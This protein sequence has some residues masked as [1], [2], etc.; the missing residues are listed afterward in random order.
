MEKVSSSHTK[1]GTVIRS[2]EPLDE[3]ALRN[4]IDATGCRAGEM[5]CEPY[6]KRD[7]SRS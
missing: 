3:K 7:C 4:T 1:G 6:E 5:H 2:K